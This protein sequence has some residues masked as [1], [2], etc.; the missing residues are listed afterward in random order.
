MSLHITEVYSMP[1]SKKLSICYENGYK[2]NNDEKEVLEWIKENIGGEMTVLKKKE[3]NGITTPDLRMDKYAE[4]KNTSGS[5]NTLDKHVRTA[6]KQTQHGWAFINI[7]GAKYN[8]H[9]AISTIKI[10]CFGVVFL[11]YGSFVGKN[12]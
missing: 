10:G 7:D 1:K 2:L 3:I 12:S 11:K 9:E 5:L 8:D 4:I 6:A